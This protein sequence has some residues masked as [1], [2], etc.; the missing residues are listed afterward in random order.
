[1]KPYLLLASLLIGT[2]SIFAQWT[3]DTDVNTAVEGLQTED[4]QSIG[5]S[6]GK[7][8]VAFWRIAPAPQNYE[9]RLQVLDASG[10]KLLGEDGM[11][12]N[13]VVEMSTFTT[14]WSVAIDKTDH[15]YI[16]FNGT[17]GNNSAYVHK[18]APDGTQVWGTSGINVGSG[19]DVKVLPLANGEVVVSWLP[20]NKGVFQK[21]DASGT[22]IY[23]APII[24]QP[25]VSNHK[26]NAG[27]LAGLSNGDFVMVIHDRGGFSP[28]ASPVAQRYRGTD[29][30]A[31]WGTP[32]PIS[33]GVSTYSNK[34]YNLVQSQDTVYLGYSGSVGLNFFSYLQRIN[35]DGSLPWGANGVD[36]ST[37]NSD[38][39]LDTK[40]AYQE[41]SE[42]IWAIC[43]YTNTSQSN[44]GEFVQKFNKTTGERLLGDLAKELFP[45]APANISH[46][47]ALQLVEDKPLF[48]VSN[49]NSNGVFPLDL[50]AVSLDNEG[51]FAWP[52]VTRPVG[53]NT[54]G[55]KARINLNRS[56]NQTCVAVWAENRTA[57]GESRAFAQPVSLS[58]VG[59]NEAL[60]FV[61]MEVSPNPN[62]GTFSIQ[63]ELPAANQVICRI[64]SVTGQ[65]MDEQ[66]D[67][68][69]QGRNIF[70]CQPAKA[71]PDGHYSVSLEVDGQRLV[72]PLVVAH[73]K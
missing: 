39:E 59:T 40:I 24:I 51:E 6:D 5:T 63:L 23:P 35:P 26:T 8:Y 16:G 28:S 21:Y 61:Q 19:Y 49:G 68:L 52:E 25:T 18:I 55:A 72:K 66:R 22:P 48:L 46:R 2:T 45:I 57:I 65:L 36:F 56:A 11:V 70:H 44:E 53:T 58:T 43:E 1:M 42:S 14:V 15:L 60:S 71:L 32:I 37:Q 34:R 54:T 27:E 64:Y 69:P 20:D 4:I 7:T 17:G 10:N 30:A 12:V 67:F 38:Y 41:G 29:G 62:N 47:G 50:L 9:M 33:N 13:D 3:T 73:Q 31:M